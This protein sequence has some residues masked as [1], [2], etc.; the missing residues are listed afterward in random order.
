MPELSD[1]EKLQ[2][3]IDKHVNSI[4]SQMAG[5]DEPTTDPHDFVQKQD[6]K[7]RRVYGLRRDVVAALGAKRP[8]AVNALPTINAAL[9]ATPSYMCEIN[10]LEFLALADAVATPS[11]PVKPPHQKAALVGPT[12]TDNDDAAEEIP[13]EGQ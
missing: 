12:T 6:I 3:L 5:F 10:A 9:S 1:A 8:D 7:R 4:R 13:E 2:V 11:Q